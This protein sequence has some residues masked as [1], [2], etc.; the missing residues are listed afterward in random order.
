MPP[1]NRHFLEAVAEVF[2]SE[3]A[4]DCV[5]RFCQE[6]DVLERQ[7]EQQQQQQQQQQQEASAEALLSAGAADA[8]GAVGVPVIKDQSFIG[9]PLPAHRFVLC[10][11]SERFTAQFERWDS[12]EPATP[13]ASSTQT[14]SFTSTPTTPRPELRIPLGS[15]AEVDSAR[16]AIRFAYTGEVQAG[17]VREVL[18]VR[19]QATYL[20][21]KGCAE[22]CDEVLR[23]MIAASTVTAQ[24]QQQE[25]V[26]EGHQP[27]SEQQAA[28]VMEFYLSASLWPDP[29]VMKD[30][31]FEA[32]VTAAK[33]QLVSYFGSTLRVLNTPSLR[34][35][36]LDLPAVA[37]EAL[38]ES[39]RFGT[40]SESSV[41]LVLATWMEAN[42]ATK[43]DAE[44]RR[45]LCRQVRLVQLNKPYLGFV[46]PAL[47]ADFGLSPDT[48]A[49]W[50]PVS[51]AEACFITHFADASEKKRKRL[52]K[53]AQGCSAYD[54]RSATYNTTP[55]AACLTFDGL[56]VA[57][58]IPQQTLEEKLASSQP[59]KTARIFWTME[60]QP[61]VVVQGF[62]WRVSVQCRHGASSAGLFKH[63]R[64]PGAFKTLNPRH[65][66]G[67]EPM[68]VD[69]C[70]HLVVERWRNG[71]CEGSVV[72]NFCSDTYVGTGK[73]WGS[74]SALPLR[75]LEERGAEAG[76]G[77]AGDAPAGG[78]GQEAA[79]GTQ[80]MLAA[81]GEY[82][83]EGKIRG[84]LTL[85]PASDEE[86]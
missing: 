79:G 64:K 86:Q 1:G 58:H 3:K 82:L 16:A 62:E 78:G 45:R 10:F 18:E 47:A 53:E 57:M 65:L 23:G 83:H 11:S 76:G 84:R 74:A 25:D 13:A 69:M 85:L 66:S 43:T 20:Q 40:D 27:L 4:S 38:L 5:I 19:R 15:E 2:G 24:Q 49:G 56:S 17:S 81:W 7:P 42:Y 39:D 70:S 61:F 33:P 60:Q 44:T 8:A 54:I 73:G 51:V 48:P 34:Q 46:L 29:A 75:P 55:R 21:I 59:G 14:A 22:A 63:C 80:Q 12:G 36:L 68:L 77:G 37:V 50:F 30:P 71:K 35:Q 67:P 52:V 9:S 26:D 6:A 41:L 72:T 31:S 28:A 32:V